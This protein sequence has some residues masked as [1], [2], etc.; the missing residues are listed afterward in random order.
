MK[1]KSNVFRLYVL[2]VIFFVPVV[3][4]AHSQERNEIYRSKSVFVEFG[5]SGVA[6]LT[7]NYDFRFFKGRSDGLGM[8]IGIGGENSTSEPF[9]GEGYTDTKLFTVPVEVNYIYGKKRF[10]F[11]IGYSFTYISGSENS[12]YRIFSSD[13][14]YF[15]ESGNFIVSYMPVG[16]RLK[17]KTD[18]FMLKFNLGPMISYTFPNIISYDKVQAWAGLAIGY[19]FY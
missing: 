10:A 1:P 17:P 14:S 7:G 8:R 13:Y 19:S 11:E 4:P 9:F 2:L 16:F 12:K 5:G 6:I 15:E 18:G 3:I